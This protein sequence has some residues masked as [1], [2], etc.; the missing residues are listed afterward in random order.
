M[1]LSA[2]HVF[3]RVALHGPPFGWCDSWTQFLGR[4][5]HRILHA[6]RFENFALAKRIK[7]HSRNALD[8]FG[9]RDKTEIAVDEFFARRLLERTLRDVGDDRL[10]QVVAGHF[11]KVIVERVKAGT[12]R[13]QAAPR[14][15]FAI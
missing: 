11:Q 14:N 1:H 15:G 9:K 2:D 13:H 3:W 4:I 12:M 7:V 6:E 8:D 5:E 10:A